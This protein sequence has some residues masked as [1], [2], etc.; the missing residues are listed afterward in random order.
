MIKEFYL[1]HKWNPNMKGYSAFLKFQNRSLTIRRF[2][3]LSRTL[4]G[5]VFESDRKIPLTYRVSCT[6]GVTGYEGPSI[7]LQNFC[8]GI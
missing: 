7:S 6:T 5:F 4:V 8:S 3:F 2:S 1:I